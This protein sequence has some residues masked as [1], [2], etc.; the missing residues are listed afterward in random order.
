MEFTPVLN[1]ILLFVLVASW[2]YFLFKGRKHLTSHSSGTFAEQYKVL[3]DGSAD[4]IFMLDKEGWIKDTNKAAIEWYGYTKSELLKMNIRDLAAPDYQVD[5]HPR[6]AKVMTEKVQFVWGHQCKDGSVIPVEISSQAVHLETGPHILSSVRNIAKRV[7]I[8]E[9]LKQRS[10]QYSSLFNHAPDPIIIHDGKTILDV[11]PAA[12]AAVGLADKSDLIGNDPYLLGHPDERQKSMER[13]KIL[14]E[15]RTALDPEEFTVVTQDNRTRQVIAKPTPIVFEGKDAIMVNYHDITDR[16]IAE[17]A[18]KESESLKSA[19]LDNSPIGISVRSVHGTLLMANKAWQKIWGVS[20]SELQERL[21]PRQKLIFNER[22]SYLGDHLPQVREVYEKGG[23]YI[24][25]EVQPLKKSKGKAEWISQIFYA[26]QDENSR[27]DKV[28]V[29]TENITERKIAQE[30]LLAAIKQAEEN[31]RR[32]KSLHNASFGGIAIHDKGLILDCNQGLA[33]ITGYS[34][35]ELVGMNGLLL[36]AE[37]ERDHVMSRIVSGYEKPY[38]SVGIT[39]A[40]KEYP[41]RLEARMIPYKGQEVRVVEFRDISDQKQ[42]EATRSAL[43]VQLRQAQKLEAVGTMVGGISHEL[44]NILQSM[45]LRSGLIEDALPEDSEIRSNFKHLINDGKRARDIVSQ[46]LTFSRKASIEM[47]PRLLQNIVE[48]AMIL[49]RASLSPRIQIVQDIQADC[50]PVLCD[51]TQIHQIIMNLFN[52]AEQAMGKE[53]GTITV[54]LKQ[55]MSSLTEGQNAE[56]VVQLTVSD[57]GSGMT[58]ET[59]EKI[60]DPFYTTK[61]VGTGTGLGLSVLHG[62]V[63]VMNGKISVNSEVGKGS[64]FVIQVPVAREE[65]IVHVEKKVAQ[66]SPDRNL[67]ILLVDDEASIRSAVTASLT[68]RGYLVDQAADGEE[69]LELFKTQVAKYDLIVTDLSMPK[70]SGSELAQEIRKMGSEIPILLSTGHLGD[71][72]VKNYLEH[73]ITGFIQKPWTAK[74]LVAAIARMNP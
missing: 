10:N 46:I 43:E 6:L 50:R 19:V 13:L 5:D 24:V 34:V 44:N 64:T 72:G 42:A 65:D 54:I 48:A 49:A 29:L 23:Y 33:E 68:R 16:K 38:E 69:G 25:P 52:N 32:F 17:K 37:H 36:I 56:T 74:Q 60:F 20:D 61:E 57:T 67:S 27:V 55:T 70:M 22:D 41:L 4:A 45:F 59:L 28:V 9:A 30:E 14:L 35:D 63:E 39:Q 15:N 51:K 66:V 7:E 40:G 58:S 31:E 2:V 18:L 62:I 73:G 47:K 1:I 11:N 3:F 12:V 26:I 21:K 8:E 53:G 71:D